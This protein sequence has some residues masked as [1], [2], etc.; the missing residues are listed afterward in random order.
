MEE[1]K[2]ALTYITL[3]SKRTLIL[4]KK[5]KLVIYFLLFIFR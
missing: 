4:M 5:Y 3:G 2:Q 1:N